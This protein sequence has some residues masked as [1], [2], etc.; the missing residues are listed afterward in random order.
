MLSRQKINATF[1]IKSWMQITDELS[2]DVND[3]WIYDET[4]FQIIDGKYPN[5]KACFISNEITKPNIYLRLQE[6]SP[7]KTKMVYITSQSNCF[8]NGKQQVCMN[9]II[10][11]MVSVAMTLAVVHHVHFLLGTNRFWLL[12]LPF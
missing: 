1:V 3:C 6:E 9:T 11:N 10:T 5:I 7:F 2:E 4:L 8:Y 12:L